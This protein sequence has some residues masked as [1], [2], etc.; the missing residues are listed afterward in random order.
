MTPVYEV[1]YAIIGVVFREDV[2]GKLL[3]RER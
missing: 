1:V 2:D 3:E